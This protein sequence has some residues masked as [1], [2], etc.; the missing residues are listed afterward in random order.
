LL[1]FG[2]NSTH[3]KTVTVQITGKAFHVSSSESYRCE[4]CRNCS[5][6]AASSGNETGIALALAK[7]KAG[8]AARQGLAAAISQATARA[9]PRTLSARATGG[10]AHAPSTPLVAGTT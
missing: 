5:R 6:I 7:H 2:I 3:G 4:A 10:T 1:F 8:L 9:A